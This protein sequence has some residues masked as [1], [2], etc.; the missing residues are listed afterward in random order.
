M[1][2]R[3]QDGKKRTPGWSRPAVGNN[4]EG[5]RDLELLTSSPSA[6]KS[7]LLKPKAPADTGLPG[8]GPRDM[9]NRV[10]SQGV[11]SPGQ[12]GEQMLQETRLR[13]FAYLG[14]SPSQNILRTTTR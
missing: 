4:V 1:T 2:F 12:G 7:P 11:S 9:D 3:T 5:V 10:E 13:I 8:P 14:H 6:I